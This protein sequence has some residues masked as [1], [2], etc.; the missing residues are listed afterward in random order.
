MNS[1]KT[2]TKIRNQTL[3]S[4]EYPTELYSDKYFKQ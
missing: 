2:Y 4:D 3:D 1:E